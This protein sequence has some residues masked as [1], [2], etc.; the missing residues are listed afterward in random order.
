LLLQQHGFL[1]ENV[2]VRLVPP[3]CP[4]DLL[5]TAIQHRGVMV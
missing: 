1:I 5:H 4:F 3:T 2:Q